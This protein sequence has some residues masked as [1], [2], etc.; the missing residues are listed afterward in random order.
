[1]NPEP[2]APSEPRYV[3]VDGLR[4]LAALAVLGHHLLERTVLGATL[5]KVLPEPLT[6][7]CH[8]GAHG[9]QVFFVISGFVIAHSLRHVEPTAGAVGNFILRRQLRLD[10]PYWA[11]LAVVFACTVLES[12]LPG[13]APRTLPTAGNVLANMSYLHNILGVAHMLDVA[14][15]LCLEIQFYLVFILILAC[16][17]ALAGGVTVGPVPLSA[18]ALVAGL[19]LF[20]LHDKVTV[21]DNPPWFVPFW[22]YFA[23]GV[24]CYWQL[25]GRLVGWVFPGFVGALAVALCL[26]PAIPPAVGLTTVLTLYLVGRAGRLTHWLGGP[27]LT[28]LGRIS[29]SLY[30]IHLPVLL[31][32]LPAGY[33]L[34]GENRGAAVLWFVLA[35]LASLGA[36]HLL[37]VLVEAPSLRLTARLKPVRRVGAVPVNSPAP[38]GLA[39]EV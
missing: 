35:A 18:V 19:G 8:H 17:R 6:F 29:Y 15:T 37:H 22:F 27:A 9:V 10:P 32:V 21:I 24:L 34:T 30:L 23:A 12:H 5:G 4:G 26:H 20:S 33:K 31:V 13:L 25:R 16:S 14:W 11:A 1:M 2:T 39:L 38:A 28:Y 36:A 7:L 3:F